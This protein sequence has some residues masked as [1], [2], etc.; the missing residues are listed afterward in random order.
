M[1]RTAHPVMSPL[2][3]LGGTFLL[4]GVVIAVWLTGGAIFSPGEL[5]VYAEGQ[6]LKG[7]DSHADFENDC[8]Q[9][10]EPALGV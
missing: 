5:S 9:C 10:H 8:T 3:C 6:P 4:L 2:G 7:F 1:N